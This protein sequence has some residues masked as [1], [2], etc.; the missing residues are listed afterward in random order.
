MSFIRG[1]FRVFTPFSTAEE[2]R[3]GVG[4]EGQ[5]VAFELSVEGMEELVVD[6]EKAILAAKAARDIF[7][8]E[9]V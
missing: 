8:K 1:V 5:A 7:T 9:T 6:L 3:I 4:P 2:V